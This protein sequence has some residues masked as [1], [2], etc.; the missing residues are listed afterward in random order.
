MDEAAGSARNRGDKRPA[1]LAYGPHT[2]AL[3]DDALRHAAA[4]PLAAAMDR[5][6]PP[7]HRA[8]PQG[9]AP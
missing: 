6:I 7:A 8:N 5:W 4:A 3:L 2:W 9:L 1:Y